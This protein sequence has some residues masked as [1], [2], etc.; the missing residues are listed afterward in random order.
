[1]RMIG[2][3]WAIALSTQSLVC[4]QSESEIYTITEPMTLS[5]EP[6]ACST[7][8]IPFATMEARYTRHVQAVLQ[9]RGQYE[10]NSEN[11]QIRKEW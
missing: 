1:M 4:A 7:P 6:T 9:T 11:V 3:L 2:L 5:S 8:L 10:C